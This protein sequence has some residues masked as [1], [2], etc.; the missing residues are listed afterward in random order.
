M[1]RSG[2][3]LVPMPDLR[4]TLAARRR[5]MGVV[6]LSLV[7]GAALLLGA[8][9]LGGRPGSPPSGIRSGGLPSGT[10]SVGPSPAGGSPA[11]S[12]SSASA[13]VPIVPVT[14]FRAAWDSTD[15]SEVAA[16]IGGTSQRYRAVEVVRADAVTIL[17]AIGA[18]SAEAGTRVV[19][20]ADAAALRRDLATHRD[21]LGFLRLGDVDPSVRALGWNGASLFGVDRVTSSA[22]WTL[23]IAGPAT[24]PA[25]PGAPSIPAYDPATAWTL[26]AGGDINLDG[27]VAYHVKTLGL[28]IDFPFD[29]GTA[30]I[31]SRYCCSSRGSLLPRAVRTGNAGV[32]RHLLSEADLAIANFENP[33]PDAFVYHPGG[34]RFS[35]DPAL[36]E[37]VT[38][39]GIDWVSLANNHVGDAGTTGIAETIR[40]LDR[41]GIQHSGAGANLAAARAPS[42]LAAGGLKV[43]ILGYDTIKPAYGAGPTTPGSNQMSA[44]RVRADI[45]AARALGADF[46]VVFPHWGVEYTANPTAYQRSLAHAAIDAGADLVV[47]NHPHWAGAIE[48]YE[49]VP[50]FYALGDFV[51]NIDRSEQ[52]EEGITLELTYTGTRLVQVRI[53][54]YLILDGSQPNFLD[55][56]GSGRGVLDQVFGASRGLLPW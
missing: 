12:L 21:R 55:P 51:F 18:T 11:P 31:L 2:H 33:A 29:G 9:S 35:A 30:R 38:N 26:V 1:P 47:G 36:I 5:T 32:V 27:S 15:A 24:P 40:N 34:Y 4:D 28:G 20:A 23:A 10:G 44:T 17:A 3:T 19:R 41:W 52:T 13:R 14:S 42:I 45:A 37:G 16:V 56:A 39:A 6:L 25:T 22:E 46:V 43:A 48:L 53:H 54:P 7:A 50:T 8:A 49:G